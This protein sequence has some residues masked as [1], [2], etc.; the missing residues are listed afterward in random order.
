MFRQRQQ[1]DQRN[2]TSKLA[3]KIFK[4]AEV[5]S[6]LSEYEHFKLQGSLFFFGY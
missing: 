2:E 4:Y 1:K 5:M 3:T 6:D